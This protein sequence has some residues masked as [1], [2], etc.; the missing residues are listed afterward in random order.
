MHANGDAILAKM[1]QLKSFVKN[2]RKQGA[3]RGAKEEWLAGHARLNKE[4]EAAER[5][6]EAAMR[7]L[8][9]QRGS[10]HASDFGDALR[11]M[12]GADAA[13]RA[14]ELDVRGRGRVPSS[15]I[16]PHPQSKAAAAFYNISTLFQRR[17][18]PPKCRVCPYHRAAT[19]NIRAPRVTHL[20]DGNAS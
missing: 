3:K 7:G 19:C 4:Q 5:E 2:Q 13:A 16:T 10:A 17:P 12:A 9:E 8:A 1:M 6:L 14:L 11:E 18:S 20:V 15:L